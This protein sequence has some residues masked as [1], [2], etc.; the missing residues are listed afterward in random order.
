MIGSRLL[1]FFSKTLIFLLLFGQVLN[2]VTA[3]WV[4]RYARS[5][6]GFDQANDLVYGADGNIYVVGYSTGANQDWCVISLQADGDTNWLRNYDGPAGGTDEAKAVI[7]GNDGNIY[8]VGYTTGSAASQYDGTVRSYTTAGATRWTFIYNGSGSGNDVLNDI[9]YGS[10]GNLYVT[11][12]VTSSA[13]DTDVFVGSITTAGDT[14]WTRTRNG[15]GNGDDGA[16]RIIYGDDGN[17]YL[18]GYATGSGTDKDFAVISWRTSGAARWAYR[19]NGPGNYRD[20]AQSIAY[21]SNA[22]YA[23]GYSYTSSSGGQD[24]DFTVVSLTTAGDTNWLRRYDGGANY[25]DEASSVVYGTDGYIYAAGYATLSGINIDFMT[26][27]FTTAGA[28]YWTSWYDGPVDQ[29][30]VGYDIVYGADSNVYA[31]GRFTVTPGV[32]DI[33]VISY[34]TTS[35]RA[36]GDTNWTYS[37]D[38]P[39][40]VSDEAYVVDYGDDDNI[41]LAGYSWG[42]GTS[43]DLVVISLRG[44]TLAVVSD[45]KA[46]EN[47]GQTM[48][49]WRTV[50][51]NNTVGFYLLRQNDRGEFVRVDDKLLP[52]LIHVPQGG[53]YQY[54][55][56]EAVAGREYIYKLVEV[57]ANGKETEYGPYAVRAEN[58]L[59]FDNESHYL[60]MANESSLRRGLSNKLHEYKT[61]VSRLEINGDK[62]KIAVNENGLYYVG[63]SEI[64]D[65]LAVPVARVI[66][67][68]RLRV[69]ELTNQG[70]RV[71]YIAGQGNQ[72][73][74][75]YGEKMQSV[76]T[77]EN[78]YWLVKGR[79]LRMDLINGLGPEPTS[80]TETFNETLHFEG[81]NYALTG[82]F[83]DPQKDFWFWDY[84]IA[85]NSSLDTALFSFNVSGVANTGS[86]SI[87]LRLQG[88]TNTDDMPDHHI[89]VILNGLEIGEAMW[90]SIREYT[91]D[92]QF[93]QGLLNEGANTLQVWALL[94][95]GVPYSIVY[96]NDFDIS[97]SRLYHAVDDKLFC[98]GGGNAVVTVSGFTSPNIYLFEITN[99]LAPK[100]IRAVTIDNLGTYRLSFCPTYDA[101]YLVLSPEAMSTA[102]SVQ[103]DLRSSLRSQYNIADYLIIA[104][105]DF[106][107]QVKELARYRT[108]QGYQ[109][110]AVDINDVMD[111]FS[112][113]ISSPLAI[114]AF[115]KFAHNNWLR[116][117]R[118]VLLI[119][120]GTY[121]YKNYLGNG[122]NVLTPLLYGTDH[123]LFSAD[124]KLADV[125]DDGMP[126][127]AI[128]RLPVITAEELGMLIEKI[129][130]YESASGSWVS[131]VL[132]SADNPDV[133]GNFTK[134]SDD[135]AELIPDYFNVEKIYLENHSIAE[136]REILLAGINDGAVLMNYVGHGGLDRLAQE[137]LLTLGDIDSLN[138]QERLPVMTAQTCV[139]GRYDIPGYDCL[140]EALVLRLEGGCIAVWAPTGLC[141]NAQS[142][143]L[144][145][146]AFNAAFIGHERV[147]GDIVMEGLKAYHHHGGDVYPLY[148]YNLLGDPALQLR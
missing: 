3:R 124:N 98:D 141:F 27:C 137:G 63:A 131:N 56:E 7:Y 60:K 61:M 42:S 8:V 67:M 70:Q 108:S 116:P 5:G 47:R 65:L 111:E 147:L 17:L 38:G 135:L 29:S 12:Y 145:T 15:A 46:Y 123:G 35:S 92:V 40:N 127:M 104:P 64:A 37:Y 20:V 143:I 99:N 83:R 125:N 138:N 72:G 76:Y 25:Y 121:D 84:V 105:L 144:A 97:Y 39:L 22:I 109:V 128:G 103:A 133:G 112:Y 126:E 89:K 23:A 114:K 68:I 41:Y 88:V 59:E 62:V 113:G 28:T 48:L 82:L 71:A 93:S 132:M 14:N 69:I 134:D 122:D 21:G 142:K 10:D 81:S 118:Y 85:G 50:S 24:D 57:E 129:I 53:V 49:E 94:D 100:L 45:F 136:A 80:G 36:P 6:T 91:V 54:L 78:V 96:I 34:E 75:F 90:D 107:D 115:L 148:I 106:K 110:K 130:A 119:G 18:A 13:T 11:G 102:V 19:Y 32:Y 74:Y 86:A 79:A 55:D 33:G 31:A 52:G 95:I 16:Y 2:G 1:N 139:V 140:S 66:D 26:R 51:E 43:R 120:N 87:S 146:G 9:V 30:D 101:Q 4:Y 58:H 44:P 77:D 117:P 73:I